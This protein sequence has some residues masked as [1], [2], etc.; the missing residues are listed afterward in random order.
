MREFFPVL[1]FIAVMLWACEEPVIHKEDQP[2]MIYITIDMY[3]GYRLDVENHICVITT[4]AGTAS[5][6]DTRCAQLIKKYG[7]V[8]Q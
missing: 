7:Q 8:E 5:I 4:G 1:V 3:T 6:N 2:G